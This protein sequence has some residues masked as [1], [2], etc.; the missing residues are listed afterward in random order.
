MSILDAKD[1]Q[2][3]Q[4]GF[5]DGIKFCANNILPNINKN[6]W[7]SVKNRLPNETGRYLCAYLMDGCI[8]YNDRLFDKERSGE[9]QHGF[10]TTQDV[11]HWMLL[12]EPPEKE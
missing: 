12:P 8:F 4:I 1:P 10:Q 2:S 11:T 9:F 5:E 3:W 7:I 6:E